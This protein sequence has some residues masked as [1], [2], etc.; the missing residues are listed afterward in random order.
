MA[1]IPS[2]LPQALAAARS[3]AL[4]TLALKAGQVLEAKVIGPAPNG[5][6]QVQVGGQVLNLTLPTLL[7]AGTTLQL[8]VQGSGA[9]LQF[10]MPAASPTLPA[11]PAP[12]PIMPDEVGLP[13]LIPPVSPTATPAAPTQAAAAVPAPVQPTAAP[14]APMQPNVAAIAPQASPVPA[15][16]QPLPASA[17]PAP[18]AAQTPTA[19][20]PSGNLPVTSPPTTSVQTPVAQAAYRAVPSATPPLASAMAEPALPMTQQGALAQLVHTEVQRQDTIQGLTTA[21]SAIAGR[22]ALPEPVARAAQA[23]MAGQV[24]IDPGKLDGAVLQRAVQSSGVFQEATLAR[25][26]LPLP[27]TDMKSALLSLRQNLS[28][29]V[30]QMAA[31]IPAAAIAPPVRGSVPRARAG[32]PPPIDPVAPAEEIGKHLLER[33]D[34]ALGRMRLHQHASL[35]EQANA[36]APADWSMDLPVLIGQQQSILHLQIHRDAQHESET[37]SERG[38]QMR[39]AIALPA[40]GEVGA[41]VS[42]RGNATGVMLWADEP[43]TAVSLDAELPALRTT[44]AGLGLNPGTVFVRQGAPLQLTPAPSGHFVDSSS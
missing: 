6:T 2:D 20:A 34:S 9:N 10:A 11:N 8:E 32:D 36:Q 14:L 29:W 44:L 30:G 43:A 31:I 25:G 39:F 1:I 23:V 4:Q 24:P 17:P 26:E 33:T 37:A 19:A 27:Q 12:M 42:L 5:G 41:Q 15:A 22:V 38:W 21:L 3:S 40:L 35:P 28:A 18:I 7:A 13:Q 16:A